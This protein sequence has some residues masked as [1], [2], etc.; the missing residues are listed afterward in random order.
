MKFNPY[1]MPNL[2]NELKI[3]H[4][5]KCKIKIINLLF[6]KTELES[7]RSWVRQNFLEIKKM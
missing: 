6:K 1:L 7:L 3:D 2:K 4:R 5:L